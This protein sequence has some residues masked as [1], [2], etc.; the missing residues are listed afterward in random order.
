MGGKIHI[1]LT[2]L[3]ISLL[4]AWHLCH[5]FNSIFAKYGFAAFPSLASAADKAENSQL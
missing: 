3:S 5:S 2:V 1:S 4:F